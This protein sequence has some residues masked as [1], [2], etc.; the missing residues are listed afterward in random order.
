MEK[1]SALAEAISNQELNEQQ[2]DWLN[3]YQ[4]SQTSGNS[5][6]AYARKHGL[7]IKSF[8]YWKRRLLQLGAIKPN[9]VALAKSPVFLPV[10]IKKEQHVGV[11]SACRVRFTN[12][13]E[14]EMTGMN[15]R[16]LEHL[17][18]SISRLPS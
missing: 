12:G 11:D 8:Y 13:I 6:A 1:E 10:R 17:L 5:M 2:R 7:A 3:H 15:E 18:A 9:P 4:A 16:E 14:C